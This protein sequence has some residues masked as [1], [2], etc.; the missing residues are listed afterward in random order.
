MSQNPRAPSCQGWLDED[1]SLA[2]GVYE[3]DPDGPVGP[4]ETFE[5]WC[6]M[7]TAGGGW[8]LLANLAS[9]DDAAHGWYDETFWLTSGTEGI[10]SDALGT[11]FK[12]LAYSEITDFTSVLIV[13]H[14][15]GA[16][17]GHARYDI[18]DPYRG[19]SLLGLLQTVAVGEN[20]GHLDLGIQTEGIFPG[21]GLEIGGK[22]KLREVLVQVDV[23]QKLQGVS[24]GLAH[25]AEDL[26]NLG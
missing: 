14:D 3:L 11:G 18:L 26:E 21:T 6:D 1:P 12:S 25:A 15:R 10:P 4:G 22:G 7:E 19:Y 24:V 8:T 20:T 23:T 2:S 5:A 13:L 17:I 9:R 16:P